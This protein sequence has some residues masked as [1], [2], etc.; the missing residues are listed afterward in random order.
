MS[1]V[2]AIAMNYFDRKKIFL[3]V[4]LFFISRQAPTS[5]VA[6]SHNRSMTALDPIRRR[7][8]EILEWKKRK[9]GFFRHAQQYI[10]RQR[11]QT[12]LHAPLQCVETV[13]TAESELCIDSVKLKIFGAKTHQC[14]RNRLSTVSVLQ[15]Q[16]NPTDP[17]E[18]NGKQ[19]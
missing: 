2:D 19:Q 18:H 6:Q 5:L 8:N 11:H 10:L 9:V 17:S 13:A 1:A 14:Q 12:N 4:F 3:S 7:K 15:A 16:Q